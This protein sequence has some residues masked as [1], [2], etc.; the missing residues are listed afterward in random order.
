MESK[1]ASE[2]KELVKH[3][4][5][6]NGSENENRWWEE[7]ASSESALLQNDGSEGGRRLNMDVDCSSGAF[8]WR[9]SEFSLA[10]GSFDLRCG[11]PP[12]VSH[13]DDKKEEAKVQTMQQLPG[14]GPRRRGRE[15]DDDDGGDA[16]RASRKD[17]TDGS[18]GDARGRKTKAKRTCSAR[19]CGNDVLDRCMNKVALC[20]PHRR[21]TD[22]VL[23]EGCDEPVRWCT[24]CKKPH[25][26]REFANAVYAPIRKL[27]YCEKGRES[28]RRIMVANKAAAQAE[29]QAEAPKAA[30]VVRVVVEGSVAAGAPRRVGGGG[31]ECQRAHASNSHFRSKQLEVSI[32]ARPEAAAMHPV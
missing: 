27:A 23:V 31:Y 25:D 10:H 32:E 18:G 29:A 4:L 15:E 8:P 6:E 20:I 30:G 14:G 24:R 11:S 28:R 13:D 9:T 7:S 16:R 2:S 26:L 3:L 22:G 1:H 12:V 17:S 21:E 5:G 19:R